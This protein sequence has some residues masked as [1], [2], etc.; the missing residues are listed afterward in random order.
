LDGF[1]S[2][3]QIVFEKVVVLADWCWSQVVLRERFHCTNDMFIDWNCLE[4]LWVYCVSA[5]WCYVGGNQVDTLITLPWMMSTLVHLV[6]TIAIE[7]DLVNEVSAP[8]ILTLKVEFN[9]SREC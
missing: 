4:V 3:F 1:I 9:G 7:T 5:R 6:Q 8:V 2:G